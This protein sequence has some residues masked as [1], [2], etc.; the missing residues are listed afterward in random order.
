MA[1]IEYV[2]M[3]GVALS[4]KST[5]VKTNFSHELIRLSY[6]DNN[7]KKE[8]DYAEKC[9]ENGKSVVI[10]DT[11]L[12]V[13]IRKQ[14]IHL[15]KMHGATTIGI[16]MNTSVNMLEQRQKRR[17]NPFPLAVIY[18]QLKELQTPT[19]DEG[20]DQ[21]IVKKDYEQPKNI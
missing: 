6:F 4:G 3:I 7:R 10:D 13:D 17:H 2:I 8:I 14:H 19:A 1:K 18:K 5:Y 11:N 21:L 12:T 16:F 9:L 15:A 20:F